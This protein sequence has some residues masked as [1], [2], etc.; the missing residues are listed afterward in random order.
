MSEETPLPRGDV[1]LRKY[2]AISLAL[3]LVRGALFDA[4]AGHTDGAQ[5]IFD[6]TA[7][8]RIAEALRC[9]ESDLA[10]DWEEYLT[11]DEVNRI[12]GW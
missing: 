7:A 10:I 2:A 6:I 9:T 12:K 5:K 4:L 11:P 3:G 1:D 8:A